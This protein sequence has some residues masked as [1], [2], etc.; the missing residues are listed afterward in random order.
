MSVRN[1]SLTLRVL[2]RVLDYPD[3]EL[4]QNMAELQAALV[5]EDALGTSRRAELDSLMNSILRMNAI[6]AEAAYVDLFDRGRATSLHLF[7]HVHGD[8]RDRGPAMIDLQQTYAQ[9]NLE[10]A[11]GELPDFL[12]AVLEFASTQPPQQARAFLGEIADIVNALFAALEGRGSHY[13]AVMGAL[14]D[15]A[16]EKAKPVKLPP[17]PSLDE[18]WE[19]PEPF[20]GCSTRGQSRPDQPQPIHFVRDSASLISG[21]AK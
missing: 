18:S 10:F 16:G 13:A 8:S 6:D 4:R 9:A 17:E 11:D 1:A 3:A 2:A 5:L 19:E 14:L 20:D 21:A 12:P 15:L 7:E